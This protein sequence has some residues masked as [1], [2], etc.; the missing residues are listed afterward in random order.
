ME[1]ANE[2]R[3]T[4]ASAYIAYRRFSAPTPQ[5]GKATYDAWS[6]RESA[7]YS[8]LVWYYGKRNK[9]FLK[10][11]TVSVGVFCYTDGVT[12]GTIKRKEGCYDFCFAGD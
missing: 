9:D 2:K 7:D 5:T 11:L 3:R 8:Q 4:V 10:T 12:R 6:H 1:N